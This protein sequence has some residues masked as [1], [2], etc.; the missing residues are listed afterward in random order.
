MNWNGLNVIFHTWLYCFV[1]CLQQKIS[2]C[3]LK[4]NRIISCGM[5]RYLDYFQ[6]GAGSVCRRCT[7][8]SLNFKKCK[9]RHNSEGTTALC[10]QVWDLPQAAMHR[11][12]LLPTVCRSDWKGKSLRAPLSSA[13]RWLYKHGWHC[14]GFLLNVSN[15]SQYKIWRSRRDISPNKTSSKYMLILSI[16]SQIKEKCCCMHEC[17]RLMS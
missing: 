9:V 8:N 11:L 15:Y 17:M 1:V 2:V 5:R 4:T 7:L 6:V 13:G 14:L 3:A 12:T 16:I 10:L